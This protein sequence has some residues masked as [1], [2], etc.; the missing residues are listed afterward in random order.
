MSLERKSTIQVKRGH[1]LHACKVSK[2]VDRVFQKDE[3][4]L[5]VLC[6]KLESNGETKTEGIML[7][8]QSSLH[9]QNS[10]STV[11]DGSGHD[12]SVP[13]QDQFGDF[14]DGFGSEPKSVFLHDCSEPIP[15]INS[16]F[17]DCKPSPHRSILKR[18]VHDFRFLGP[19]DFIATLLRMDN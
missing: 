18:R 2:D 7:K 6:N 11:R 1:I 13:G 14:F 4:D 17:N 16:M 3:I 19:Q 8:D 9:A 10:S 15:S 12:F 5:R